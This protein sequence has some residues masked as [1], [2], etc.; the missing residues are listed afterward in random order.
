M[1]LKS[2]KEKKE[3][4]KVSQEIMPEFFPNWMKTINP[5]IQKV[6]ELQDG[7]HEHYI[8]AH[9]NTNETKNSAP[10]LG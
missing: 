4:K 10:K 7:K 6:K 8:K 5:Q 9:N 2:P 1:Q 3:K